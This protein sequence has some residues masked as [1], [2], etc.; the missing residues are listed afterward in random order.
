M[1]NDYIDYSLLNVLNKQKRF[2]K[3]LMHIKMENLYILEAHTS[4]FS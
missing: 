4:S 2:L 3:Y 1:T